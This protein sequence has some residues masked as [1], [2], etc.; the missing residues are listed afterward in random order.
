MRKSTDVHDL[1]TA[2]QKQARKV[3]PKVFMPQNS[4]VTKCKL[5]TPGR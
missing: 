1:L 3:P 4:A 5:R 2:Y